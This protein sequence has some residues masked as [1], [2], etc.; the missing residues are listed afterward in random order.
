MSGRKLGRTTAH[1]EM[2]L[3]N[4]ATSLIEKERVRTTVAKAKELRPFVEKLITMGKTGTLAARRRALAVLM[5]EDAV[6]RLFETVAPRF[7]ERAGGYTRIVKLSP[8]KGDGAEMAVIELVGSEFK[9]KEKKKKDKE[10]GK[11]P[12]KA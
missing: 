3:R 12:A 2:L 4:L 9:A 8:R 10:K 6:T 1:R 11:K 7:S 5:K